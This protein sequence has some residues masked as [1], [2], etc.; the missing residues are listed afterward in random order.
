M[1]HSLALIAV[2]ALSSCAGKDD[3][4]G[5]EQGVASKL[6]FSVVSVGAPKRIAPGGSAQVTITLK[7]TGTSTWQPGTVGLNYVGD[8]AITTAR[9]PLAKT[10]KPNANGTFTGTLAVPTQIGRYALAWQATSGTELFGAQI[11]ALTEV[12]CSDGVFCNGDERQVNGACVAGPPPCDDGEGCTADTCD[13]N[14]D[15]CG[16]TLGPNC[17]ACFAKNCN[18]SCR[19]KFCGDDGCGGSCGECPLGESCVAGACEVVTSPGSCGAPIPLLA[20]GETL[21]GQHNLTGDTTTGINETVPSCNAT[22]T[23]PELVYTFTITA[24]DGPLGIDARSSGFD[25]VLHLRS[26]CNDAGSTLGCTDDSAPPGDF[27]SR[28]AALLAP[29]TYYLLVDGFDGSSKGP[30]DLSVR[31]ASNCV[32]ACDGRFCGN[33]DGCGG[34][35]GICPSGQECNAS[36]RCVASPCTPDCNGRKCGPDGCGGS[37]G[38]CTK[39]QLCVTETGQCKSFAVCDNDRPV[40]NPPCSSQ[41][42]CGTDCDCHRERDPRPDLVVSAERMQNEV[43]FDT[44]DFSSASCAIAEGCVD[45]PGIRRLLRFSV[46]AINQGQATLN[47]PDPAERPDLF[48]FSPCHGHYHFL[49]FAQ[50][51]LLDLQGNLVKQGKKLAYCMEDTVQVHVGPGVACEKGF[52]CASQGIQRGWSDLYGNG[53]DCQWL[54][55][56]GVPAGNYQLSATVNPKRQFEES[57]FDNNTTT[58]PVTIP[59]P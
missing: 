24:A 19:A 10:T 16:H 11:T 17:A 34:D 52:D 8:A 14:K 5:T 53:L 41:E 15:L 29:G 46:E 43:L 6:A 21:L 39:G 28:V 2:F 48:E 36:G 42:Y 3:I 30:F 26:A 23:A 58:V 7:N 37:C 45:G 40:C 55:I 50:F 9:L 20:A 4:S 27:G 35:C 13:E 44:R 49:G 25:T 51:S 12:T 33:T 47:I 22:S 56:T 57:S 1:R 59:A 32:P 31:F 54:D 38:D 18:P